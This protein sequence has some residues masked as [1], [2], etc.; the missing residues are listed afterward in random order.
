MH[1]LLAPARLYTRD[2]V[3]ARP[4]A[5]PAEPGVYAWY[6]RS[7][8]SRVPV[9]RV[10]RHEGLPLLYVGISPSRPP[11]NT[12]AE[13]RQNLRKRVRYHFRGNAEGSTLRLTLGTLL[14]TELGIELTRVGSGTT[15]T[16]AEGERVLSEWMGN[17]ALVCWM[18]HP[19]PWEEEARLIS[20]VDLP[21]NLAG[22]RQHP[23]AATLSAIRC[24]AKARAKTL[25]I[26]PR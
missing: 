13:S 22:N 26:R 24:S 9:E 10:H 19:E 12:M 18:P 7:V 6:F 25:D 8:P 21:L 11:S 5:V 14:A 17:N 16:F 20:T 4:S 15:R 3:L 2:E 23:F 1:P